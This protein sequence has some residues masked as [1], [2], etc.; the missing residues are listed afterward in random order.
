[1]LTRAT[2]LT[3]HRG[4]FTTQNAWTL[5]L[6]R[7][8]ANE[9]LEQMD[10]LAMNRTASVATGNKPGQV[11]AAENLRAVGQRP[12]DTSGSSTF[13]LPLGAF[14]VQGEIHHRGTEIIPLGAGEVILDRR[15]AE[16]LDHVIQVDKRHTNLL[17][18]LTGNVTYMLTL[19]SYYLNTLIL[20]L[21]CQLPSPLSDIISSRYHNRWST[22]PTGISVGE[23][24]RYWV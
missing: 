19:N 10:R 7:T 1:M 2:E 14:M 3:T 18:Q 12:D 24:G 23:V 13:A 20:V 4:S 11:F 5:I 17:L 16:V 22:S 21:I 6:W 15:V 9:P 8:L